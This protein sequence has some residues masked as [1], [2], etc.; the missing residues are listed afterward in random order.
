MNTA[1]VSSTANPC[2]GS[3]RLTTYDVS[4]INKALPTAPFPDTSGVIYALTSDVA[5]I[6]AGTKAVEPLVLR[7]NQG[8]CLR[9]TLH[10]ETTP[11]SL[12]GGTRAGFDAGQVWRNQQLASGA[13][14]GLNPDTTVPV[15]STIT[16]NYY[17][18]GLAGTML[19]QN[20][21]S[22]GSLRHGAY[23][24]LI[25]EPFGS[26]WSDSVTN[27][28]L[29]STRTATQAI[30]RASNGFRF[31][32]FALTMGTTDQQYARSIVPY[33]EM[34]A[35]IGINSPTGANIP[36]APVSGAP[37]GT[38]NNAG[39][40]DKGFNNVNY[41]T[42]ALTER[43][44][45][46]ANVADYTTVTVNGGYGLAFSSNQFGDPDT[47]VLRAFK[48]DLVA[49]RIGVGASDQFHSFT[50]G[51]HAFPLDW[52]MP[53][54]Q[55]LAARTIT[56]GETLDLLPVGGAGGPSGYTGDYLYGDARQPFQ[57]AGMWGIFR[58]QPTGSGGIAAL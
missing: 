11:G 15:G 40:F 34:I 9:V 24:M 32:E 13:A 54:S 56:A 48:G 4:L 58:V 37:P 38:A 30:I 46:T 52:F 19:F 8:D 49:F 45:L 17:T 47:P 44:G 7:A 43:L 36:A 3:A 23:G 57:E 42:E 29:T 14:V 33:I 28:T 6:Q 10:N 31:R 22:V 27:A 18:D 51:G 39:S 50:V 1:V 26:T 16:Y 2:P 20:L 12:Y 41:H 53:N 35:G 5:A 55:I 21:G 25:V